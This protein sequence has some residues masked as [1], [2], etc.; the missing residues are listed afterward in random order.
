MSNGALPRM[1][2]PLLMKEPTLMVP[3]FWRRPEV[4]SVKRPLTVKLMPDGITNSPARSKAPGW[5][6]FFAT[7]MTPFTALASW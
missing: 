3:E 1:V 4:S 6:R 2:P 5:V 7:V